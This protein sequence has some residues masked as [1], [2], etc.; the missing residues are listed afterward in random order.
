MSFCVRDISCPDIQN[1]CCGIDHP[2]AGCCS[3]QFECRG[4]QGSSDVV[5]CIISAR[6]LKNCHLILEQAFKVIP[7]G[8]VSY[9]SLVSVKIINI[10]LFIKILI[11]ESDFQTYVKTG[12][13]KQ[14]PTSKNH[15]YFNTNL[16]QVIQ[17]PTLHLRK[18]SF[19]EKYQKNANPNRSNPE[20]L[21]QKRVQ[22]SS[23]SP[24]LLSL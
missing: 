8:K 21:E 18:S 19:W 5:A 1:G 10:H 17:K 24:V 2:Q 20:T 7:L 12:V 9:K 23:T 4:I 16:S 11:I 15:I 22:L 14:Q 13:L 3:I 6:T